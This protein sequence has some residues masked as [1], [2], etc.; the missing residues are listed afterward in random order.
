MANTRQVIFIF[1]TGNLP[2]WFEKQHHKMVGAAV[3]IHFKPSL[4]GK[5]FL[6]MPELKNIKY[7]LQK[8][9]GIQ[10]IKK[11]RKEI[12]PMMQSIEPMKGYDRIFLLLQCLSKISTPSA[13]TVLTQNFTSTS[14][15]L[16]NYRVYIIAC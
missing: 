8:N 12:G 11:L 15:N 2:H 7:L 5:D 3:V 4:F 10:L 14:N 16:F 9:D 13:Y 6:A 1:M